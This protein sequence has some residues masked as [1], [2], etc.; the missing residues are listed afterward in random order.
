MPI[1]GLVK[2]VNL[3]PTEQRATTKAVSPGAAAPA[4]GGD[5]FGAYAVLGAL[6]FAV[7]ALALYVLATNSIKDNKAELA[8]VSSELRTTQAQAQALQ[9]FADF[10]QL[11][12]ARVAT[13][14][15]L[16]QSRFPWP[17]TLDDVSRALPTDVYVK[18]L[19]G[20]TS[21]STGGGSSIRGALTAPAV[22]LTGCT[23]NQASVARLMSALRGVRGATRVSL[24]KS[25]VQ[26][27]SQTGITPSALTGTGEPGGT[28]SE[29]C[30]TG[31]PPDFDVIVFFER[32]PIPASAAPNAGAAA[33]SGPTGAAGAT[34]AGPTGS[35][36]ATTPAS[37]TTT[38]P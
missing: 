5:A 2:A 11:S 22:E 14:R 24:A 37:A 25:D 12:D 29:P 33:V 26:E 21:G 8:R 18:S 32:A 16:A 19:D 20:T 27:T 7:V 34:P 6:A 10:K 31:S 4:P 23:R 13:V 38:T 9:S 15:G 1:D 17:R 28:I 36:G 35:T 30:P 3:I